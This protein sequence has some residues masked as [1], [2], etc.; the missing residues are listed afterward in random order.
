MMAMEVSPSQS[1]KLARSILIWAWALP[2][3]PRSA[4][5]GAAGPGAV[6]A[7]LREYAAMR[8]RTEADPSR[9]AWEAPSAADPVIQIP[10]PESPGARLPR[11][12][13]ADR[14]VREWR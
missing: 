2:E 3:S 14:L 7:G 4:V 11:Q 6:W 13:W 10:W 8:R 12:A 1:R 9:P 5:E